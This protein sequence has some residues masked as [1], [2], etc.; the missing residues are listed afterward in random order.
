MTVFINLIKFLIAIIIVAF[1]FISFE[2]AQKRNEFLT[3]RLEKHFNK[4][5]LYSDINKIQCISGFSMNVL[6]C[7][8]EYI[9]GKTKKLRTEV[10]KERLYL[11]VPNIQR[12]HT[13][14]KVFT[15]LNAPHIKQE[16]RDYKHY[17]DLVHSIVIK[18][19]SIK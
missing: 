13:Q 5:T 6:E 18:A 17:K 9:D 16:L 4:D 8:I 15:K 14:L 11:I 3:N 19:Q 12:V 1:L 10:N 7:N 2:G